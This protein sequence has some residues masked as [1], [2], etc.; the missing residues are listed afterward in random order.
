MPHGFEN[1]KDVQQPITVRHFT[2][3]IRSLSV[4]I[5]NLK[6]GRKQW[7]YK[8]IKRQLNSIAKSLNRTPNDQSKRILF[9][10]NQKSYKKLLKYR[11]K[12]YEEQLMNKMEYL[13]TNNK[14]EFWKF[15]KS[16]KNERKNDELPQLN[17]LIDHFI[18]LFLQETDNAVI[19]DTENTS[20]E[21][22]KGFDILN[23]PIIQK[24]VEEGIH[25]LK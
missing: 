25:N 13:Y 20:N 19:Y 5:S 11:K 12:Q 2:I 6:L 23:T 16:M 14:S 18:N 24:E 8:N 9:Y 3:T 22:K 17:T 15:L 7:S 1:L 10:K 4:E 21:Q